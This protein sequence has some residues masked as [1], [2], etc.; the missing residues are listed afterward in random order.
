[1]KNRWDSQ[2][3]IYQNLDEKCKMKIGILL[4]LLYLSV[5]STPLKL[6]LPLHLF[7]K[8]INLKAI[9]NIVQKQYEAN[10]ANVER[11][12]CGFW[13]SMRC[14]LL[15]SHFMFIL[16][17]N[18]ILLNLYQ[19]KPSLPKQ[20]ENRLQKKPNYLLVDEAKVYRNIYSLMYI[21]SLKNHITKDLTRSKGWQG[22]VRINSLVKLILLK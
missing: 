3:R 10:S 6:S 1:M 19:S 8:W 4:S 14:K 2:T 16:C 21:E 18:E 11:C 9:I 12:S 13:E 5:F 22:L 17:C 7:L 20:C 15:F